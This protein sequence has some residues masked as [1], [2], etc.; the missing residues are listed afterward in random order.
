MRSVDLY[1]LPSGVS[2][3]S[4][5]R[6]S[7]IAIDVLRASTTITAALAAGAAEIFPCPTIDQARQS[8]SRLDHALLGGERGGLRIEGFDLSNSPQAWKPDVV[9]GR[10][11][12]FTT[13]NGTLAIQACQKAGEVLIASFSNLAA[14]CSHLERHDRPVAI[15]CAG[16]DG[17]PTLEDTLMG[18][19]ICHTL[20]ESAPDGRLRLT[21]PARAATEMWRT[22]RRQ[23]TAGKSLAEL[24]CETRGGKNLVRLGL[25]ADIEYASRIDRFDFVPF[26][27]RSSGSLRADVDLPGRHR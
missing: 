20:A 4:L 1:N 10:P 16:T 18:G 5:S 9:G 15:V 23:I 17:Q 3:E 7:A 14:V 19:A 13:T 6:H 21:P 11:V 24:L 25:R 12:A 22:A 27:D 2:G 26:L 8:A